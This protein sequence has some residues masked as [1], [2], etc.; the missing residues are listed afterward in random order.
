[1][2]KT[3]SKTAKTDLELVNAMRTAGVK[4][5]EQAFNKL[6]KKYHDSVL[7]HFRGLVNDDEAAQELV[8]EAFVKMS[9]KINTF[10]SETAVFSTWLFRIT[11]NLFIDRTR[12]KKEEAVSLSDLAVTDGE[13]HIIEFDIESKESNPEMEV[14]IKERDKRINVIIDSLKSKTLKRIVRLRYFDGMSYDEIAEETELPLGTVKAFL[15]RAKQELKE[16][17]ESANIGL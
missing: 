11:K 8:N 10:N 3:L 4:E 14:I 12:Q 6:Y 5:S 9:R 2:E 17:F 1:M 15:F 13:N 16:R 7:F